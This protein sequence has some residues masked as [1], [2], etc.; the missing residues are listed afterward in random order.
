MFRVIK[1]KEG[2]IYTI[3]RS[4]QIA[5][6]KLSDLASWTDEYAGTTKNP[7]TQQRERYALEEIIAVDFGYINGSTNLSFKLI[8][9]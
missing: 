7:K 6:A 5:G 1:S 8:K 3:L 4:Q 2:Q 9:L